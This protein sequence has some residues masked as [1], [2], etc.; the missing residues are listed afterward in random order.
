[1]AGSYSAVD[2][3]SVTS[4]TEEESE[5]VKGISSPRKDWLNTARA[6]E[7]NGTLSWIV[8]AVHGGD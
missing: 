5:L 4:L 6:I 3:K 7:Q 2:R 1:M 8:I